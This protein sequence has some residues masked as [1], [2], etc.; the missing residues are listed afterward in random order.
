VPG[1]DG[2]PRDPRVA[3]PFG[4]AWT[5]GSL[6]IL[7][8]AGAHSMTFHDAVGAGGVIDADGAP[9]PTYH[10]LA[11]AAALRSGAL[12]PVR[13]SHRRELAALAVRLAGRTTVLLANLTPEPRVARLQSDLALG[14]T[15]VELGPY[16]LQRLDARFGLGP[17]IAPLV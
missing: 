13:V 4:A 15:V 16:G 7:A 17:Q 2:S 9:T 1:A 8:A 6:A 12:L 10:V 3:T 11:A 14:G 5:L